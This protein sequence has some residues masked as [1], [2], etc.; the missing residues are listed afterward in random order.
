MCSYPD[1]F[2]AECVDVEVCGGFDYEQELDGGVDGGEE[3][4]VFAKPL[5][6]VAQRAVF[7]EE[8]EGYER[9]QPSEDSRAQDHDG[10]HYRL[11]RHLVKRID[12]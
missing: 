9:R 7:A 8:S 3:S 12:M 5:P 4:I 2:H 11:L 10:C 1:L 6:D